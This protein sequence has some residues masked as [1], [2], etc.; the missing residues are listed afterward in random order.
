MEE[1]QSGRGTRGQDDMQDDS[2]WLG[3]KRLRRDDV[4]RESS[5]LVLREDQ[6]SPSQRSK[7]L[8]Y[9]CS[10]RLGSSDQT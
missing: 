7:G 8:D 1:G 3:W 6:I 2:C 4:V 5:S 9:S 10:R